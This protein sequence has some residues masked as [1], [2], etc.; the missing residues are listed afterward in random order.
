MLIHISGIISGFL[1]GVGFTMMGMRPSSNVNEP[2][3]KTVNLSSIIRAE[4][5]CTTYQQDTDYRCVVAELR[6]ELK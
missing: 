2:S 3:L 1:M 5:Q 6:E 4:I